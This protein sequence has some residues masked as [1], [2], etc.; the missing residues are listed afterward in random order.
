[1]RKIRGMTL[2]ELLTVITIAAVLAMVAVPSFTKVIAKQRLKSAATNLQIALLTA[3]SESLKRNASVC[4]ST[5][6]TECASSTDWSGGWYVVNSGTALHTFPG[7][8]NLT[9]AGP[10]TGITFESSGRV[11][12]TSTAICAGT[13]TWLKVTSPSISDE[14]YLNIAAMGAP[15]VATSL[16]TPCTP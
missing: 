3:R 9:I 11:G 14:R 1:M 8:S 4:V 6:S 16:S 2:I 10:S 5:S 15:S 12:S 7:Y 13:N